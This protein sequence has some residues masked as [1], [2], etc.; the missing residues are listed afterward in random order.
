MSQAILYELFAY[1]HIR[2]EHRPDLHALERQSRM[3]L[4]AYL[5]WIAASDAGSET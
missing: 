1:A 2:S 3:A 5:G 4:H